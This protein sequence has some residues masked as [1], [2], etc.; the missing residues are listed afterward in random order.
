VLSTLVASAAVAPFAA[1]HFHKSQQYAVLANLIALPVCNMLVMPAALAALI[2]MPFGLEA[3]PLQV[4]GWGIE[5]MV[6]IATRVAALPGAVVNVPAM[7]T[8]AFMLM[9]TGGLWLMLWQTRW[10]W[11][12]LAVIAGGAVLAPTLSVPDILIGRD[13]ALVAVRG[14]DGELSAV[15]ATRSSFE[16]ERWLEHDGAS[17]S[18]EAAAE[19]RQF[20][21]DGIGCRT[22][23]KGI[24]IAVAKHPAAFA[25]DCRRAGILVSSLVGPRDCTGP[26]AL[27]DFFAARRQGTHALYIDK[28]GAIRIETVA[29]LRGLRP[30]SM[31][32]PRSVGAEAAD[33]RRTA[34]LQ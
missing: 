15:G 18:L 32:P 4:M 26:K 34:G 21:C 28:A 24:D 33:D 29:G 10:R 1:Y 19:G 27:I 3:W 14:A 7:P 13:G 25:E 30:W 9:V 8:L 17:S 16:L 2:A 12:G 22:T 23:V 6:W 31:P 11:L 20:T 5:A